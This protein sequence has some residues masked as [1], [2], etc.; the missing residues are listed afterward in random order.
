MKDI[1]GMKIHANDEM[2]LQLKQRLSETDFFKPATSY[3]MLKTFFYVSLFL[4]FFV[5]SLY[6]SNKNIIMEYLFVF[7]Y[8]LVSIMTGVICHDATHNVLHPNKIINDF[9]GMTGFNLFNG[10]SFRLWSQVHANHHK[11]TQVKERESEMSDPD[12]KPNIWFS[13]YHEA[14]EKASAPVRAVQ[15]FQGYYFFIIA[16]FYAFALRTESLA[17]VFKNFQKSIFEIL[18][19]VGHYFLFILVVGMY[20]GFEIAF[21]H[22]MA[23][24][25][26]TS[27]HL[28]MVFLPNHGAMKFVDEGQ[29]F[30]TWKD[31]IECS[32]NIQN[33]KIFDPLFGGLNY[34]IE[35]HLFPGVAANRLPLGKKIIM[36]FCNENG[37]KYTCV[38]YGEAFKSVINNLFAVGASIKASQVSNKK[39]PGTG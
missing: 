8:G 22:Y 2:F 27:L 35:H 7:L 25:I 37:I 1:G 6:F 15:Q 12:L 33:W 34:H 28:T 21:Y 24:S 23:Y 18:F 39:L 14:A 26:V 36:S 3:Y 10:N 9:I 17:F 13:T 16:S 31:Q 30:P 32:R 11:F 20:F 4:A 29:R 19:I 5:S 38:G